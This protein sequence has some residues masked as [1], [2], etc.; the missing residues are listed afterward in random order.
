MQFQNLLASG[1]S[2]TQDAIGG[3]PP[4]SKTPGGC[5]FIDDPEYPAAPCRSWASFLSRWLNVTSFA[6][7]A[8]GGHGIVYT[9]KTII[10]ALEKYNYH[11]NNTLVIFNI[12]SPGRFDLFCDWDSEYKS[13]MVYWD[14][15]HF[16]YTV[17]EKYSP[18]W[19]DEFSK[20]SV[21]EINQ[22]SIDALS[23]LFTYLKTNN[24]QFVFTVMAEF[25]NIP[26]LP[27]VHKYSD[28][29]VTFGSY[30]GMY[31]YA[32]ANNLLLSDDLHPTTEA[33]KQFAK[34]AYDFIQKKP[35]S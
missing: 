20:L 23:E 8:G 22:R 27:L 31:E 9:K 11:P 17:I 2:F 33:H 12:T 4:T 35:G 25:T 16:D 3:I 14:Q 28:H 6:N 29:M 30:Q 34:F 15:T 10:D 7:F 26:N 18:P 24:Y 19:K 13:S 21:D 32:K 5:S 1:C